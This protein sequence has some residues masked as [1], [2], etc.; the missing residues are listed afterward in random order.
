[1][2][3]AAG[4]E[5]GRLMQRRQQQKRINEDKEPQP[6]QAPALDPA[7]QGRLIEIYFSII[8]R[9]TVSPSDFTSCLWQK[10]GWRRPPDG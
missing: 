3:I 1:V 10:P 2:A 6:E 7:P 9:K 5:Q 8:Q 4:N